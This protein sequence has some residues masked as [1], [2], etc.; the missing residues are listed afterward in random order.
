MSRKITQIIAEG[1]IAAGGVAA[2]GANIIEFCEKVAPHLKRA[3]EIST[4]IYQITKQEMSKTR[5]IT[6][7]DQFIIISSD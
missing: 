1:I 5:D 7:H 6:Y 4:E 3:K 2:A